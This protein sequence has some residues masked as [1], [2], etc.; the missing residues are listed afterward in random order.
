MLLYH[1]TLVEYRRCCVSLR[2]RI[3]YGLIDSKPLRSDVIS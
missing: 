1:A 2:R 3:I